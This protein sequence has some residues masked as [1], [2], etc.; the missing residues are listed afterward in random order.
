M[1]REGGGAGAQSA[2]SGRT[3]WRGS[4]ASWAR[5]ADG[6]PSARD[7]SVGTGPVP[8]GRRSVIVRFSPRCGFYIAPA[9]GV[10]VG[11]AAR[12]HGRGSP[13]RQMGVN[14]G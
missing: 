7:G 5:G 1:G 2:A 10:R 8:S 3:R 14:G 13:W 4:A 6:L 9:H 11:G 12:P